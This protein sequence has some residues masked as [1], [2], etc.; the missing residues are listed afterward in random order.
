MFVGHTQLSQ[1]N[2]I[3][4]GLMIF[5]LG[6]YPNFPRCSFI[7]DFLTPSSSSAF[8]GVYFLLWRMK[9][10][11]LLVKARVHI[12]PVLFLGYSLHVHTLDIL[13]KAGVY[14]PIQP[15]MQ[16]PIQPEIFSKTLD[17]RQYSPL[18][19]QIF[20]CLKVRGVSVWGLALAPTTLSV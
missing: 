18:Q 5:Y 10:S 4:L 3:K 9:F 19:Y 8:Y 7:A 16:D 11:K 14:D 2:I 13:G 12:E 17:L 15:E 20:A 6:L 1:Q